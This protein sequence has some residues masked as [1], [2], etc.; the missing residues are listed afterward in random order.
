MP[1]EPERRHPDSMGEFNL[2]QDFTM[3]A[4]PYEL[5]D[6]D[7]YQ[8][9]PPPGDEDTYSFDTIPTLTNHT[10]PVTSMDDLEESFRQPT[11][12][13]PWEENFPGAHHC[14]HYPEA[15]LNQSFLDPKQISSPFNFT[16]AGPTFL[17][18]STEG[19]VGTVE[20]P[21]TARRPSTGVLAKQATPL[22]CHSCQI[23]FPRRTEFK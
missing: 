17:S 18:A 13:H 1:P 6:I 2:D 5:F 22:Y 3:A 4:L 12:S 21:S 19:A 16:S 7:H 11:A 20:P 9:Y 10:S 15:D 8:T 14:V 23:S